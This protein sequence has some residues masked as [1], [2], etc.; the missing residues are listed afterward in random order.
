MGTVE[1]F[2]RLKRNCCPKNLVLLIME[3]KKPSSLLGSY[4]G[5]LRPCSAIQIG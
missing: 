3:E 4:T 2:Q 1:R 5:Y